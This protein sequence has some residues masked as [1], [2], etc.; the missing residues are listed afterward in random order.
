MSCQIVH[1]DIDDDGE[2]RYA[3]LGP[4]FASSPGRPSPEAGRFLV[5]YT[6]PDRPRVY[7]NAIVLVAP[8]VDGLEAAR[9]AIREYIGWQ[10]VEEQLKGQDLDL[11]RKHLL[12]MAKADAAKMNYRAGPTSILHSGHGIRK[13]RSPGVQSCRHE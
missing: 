10:E 8:S 2:F 4:K 3:I 12:D 7:R 9:N 11:N 5:E 13:E 1:R 6:G